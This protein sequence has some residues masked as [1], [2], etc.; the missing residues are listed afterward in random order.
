MFLVLFLLCQCCIM[1]K[2]TKFCAG[3]ILLIRLEVDICHD[4]WKH[5]G[6]N[7]IAKC[8]E[9]LTPRVIC[10]SN[11]KSPVSNP[12]KVIMC[13]VAV[14]CFQ[15]CDFWWKWYKSLWGWCGWWGVPEAQVASWTA[16]DD[17][18]ELHEQSV[19]QHKASSGQH[20]WFRGHW[21]CHRWGMDLRFLHRGGTEHSTIH[22]HVCKHWNWID[23]HSCI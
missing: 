17:E 16:S 7:Q 23:E 19:G 6:A 2:A 11:L 22:V 14:Y 8:C 3:K 1:S 18:R 10:L 13:S 9:A 12:I 20:L 15:V 5:M 21:H 4:G